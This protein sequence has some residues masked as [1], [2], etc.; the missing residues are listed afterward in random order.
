MRIHRTSLTLAKASSW[1][2]LGVVWLAGRGQAGE[3][4]GRESRCD[5]IV[6]AL[7]VHPGEILTQDPR[8]TLLR[9][10]NFVL[11]EMLRNAVNS[12]AQGAANFFHKGS[13]S[14]EPETLLQ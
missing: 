4:A 9:I 1:A 12:L 5:P 2:P 11:L 8:G 7:S 14:C 3:P 6:P 10:L 13:K